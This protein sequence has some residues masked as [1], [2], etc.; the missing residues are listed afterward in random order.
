MELQCEYCKNKFDN[1]S[2]L[3]K[4]KRIAKYCLILQG[5]IE[6][7]REKRRVEKEEKEKE[8]KEKKEK[9]KEKTRENKFRCEYCGVRLTSRINYCGHLDICIVK[10]I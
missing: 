6:D 8:E 10:Y 1:N 3:F 7:T 5:K 2:S 9:E 4:H